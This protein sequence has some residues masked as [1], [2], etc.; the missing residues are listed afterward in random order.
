MAVQGGDEKDVEVVLDGLPY[1]DTE[2]ADP[3]MREEVD[4]MIKEEMRMFR[5]PDYLASLPMPQ[6]RGTSLVV[7]DMFDRKSAPAKMKFD[8]ARYE[9]KPPKGTDLKAWKG[10]L[11]RARIQ[12]E[13]QSARIVNLELMKRYGSNAWKGY[14]DYLDEFEKIIS[15][16]L[17]E[18]QEESRELNRKRKATQMTIASSLVNSQNKFLEYAYKNNELHIVCLEMEKQVK[19]LRALAEKAK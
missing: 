7:K 10:A 9:I 8:S 6:T 13:H 16:N 4:R 11:D 2:Y 18:Y 14:A 12:L 15:K 1:I 19:K 3:K 5:P 17:S